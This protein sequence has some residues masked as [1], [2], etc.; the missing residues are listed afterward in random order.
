MHTDHRLKIVFCWHMH[1]PEYRDIVTGEYQQPWTYLHAVKD[2]VDMAAH[3][4]A[5]PEAKAVVNFTPTLLE[6]IEDY[7]AQIHAFLHEDG[8]IRD[9]LLGSLD[10]PALPSD[11]D[12]RICLIKAC[13][14]A[15]EERLID[16]FPEYRSL[17]D[18]ARWFEHKEGDMRYIDNQFLAD[19]LMWY[20]LAWLGETVRRQDER[21]KALLEK[22]KA[23]TLHDRRQLLQVIAEL[24]KSVIPRYRA[25]HEKGQVELSFTP[26]AHPIVPLL[27]DIGSAREAMPDV[28]LPQ[29]QSYPGG[30]ERT[31][32]HME[33]GFETFER[34]FG[35]R[36]TGCWPSEGSVSTATLELFEEYGIKWAASGETVFHNSLQRSGA[37]GQSIHRPYRVSDCNVTCFFRDDRMSDAIG[38]EFSKWHAD[39]AVANLV[40]NLESIAGASHNPGERVVSII[41][42]G[43]NAWE[44][45]PE[46]G[47]YFL[48]TVYK[49]I[50]ES[51]KLRLS[52]FSECLEESIPPGSFSTLVAGSW[53]Y[54]TFSTWIGDKDKNRGW[55]ML[56]DAKRAFDEALPKLDDAKKRAAAERQMAICEGSDWFWWFGDYNPEGAVN[57]FDRLYRLQLANLY[58]LLGIEPPDYLAHSFTQGRGDPA[59]GGVMRKGQ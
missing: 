48:S 11:P 50:A 16:R 19:L 22:G 4:E 52:T 55:D 46:N 56:A 59:A 42:D 18:I 32:W 49:R 27:L 39:D 43:E 51:S 35:F 15:N 30:R 14:R 36:P 20:H 25:L 26:Y 21:V 28:P 3:I 23:F 45:Y 5:T 53:V 38:F 13:L 2:Y 17:A 10:M 41:M 44:F 37:G 54:G 33:K 31:H 29:L 34:C 58:Q 6:Q 9:P 7:V 12:G 47:Y 24:L 40:H 1:Q 8:T 57:D